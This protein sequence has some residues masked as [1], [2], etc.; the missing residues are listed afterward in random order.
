MKSKSLVTVPHNRYLVA[1]MAVILYCT[2]GISAPVM[3]Q[4]VSTSTASVVSTS[5]A[6][7]GSTS[8]GRDAGSLE[9]VV[10]TAEK[11]SERLQDVPVPVTAL[12]AVTLADRNQFRIQDYFTQ[13]PGLALTPNENNGTATIAI[14]GITSGDNTNPTVGI[15]VD[16]IPFGSSTSIGAG[17]FAPDFDPSD[18]ARV[19]VLRGPQ[20]TLYGASSIGGLLKYVTVDPSFAGVSGRVEAGLASVDGGGNLGYNVSAGV[21]IPLTDSL[22][23]RISG[24]TRDN[25]GYIHNVQSGETDVNKTTVTG[26]HLSALWRPTDDFSLKL[27]ALYQDNKIF[28]SSFVTVE[29]GLGDWQQRFLPGTG[30]VDRTFEVFSANMS[31]ILGP[32]DVTSVTGYSVSRLHDFLDYTE[33]FGFITQGVFNTNPP[34]T[35]AGDDTTTYKFNQEIRLA[36]KIGSKVDLLL[37]GYYTH[38]RSPYLLQIIGADAAGQSIGGEAHSAFTS[39]YAEWSGFANLTY[40]FTD[41]FDVQV[42]GRGTS[43][44]ETFNETDSGPYVPLFENA[45]S[46]NSYGGSEQDHAFTYLV[47]PRYVVSQDLMIYARLASGYRPGGI[48][49]GVSPGQPV[50]P[51]FKHDTTENYELG[52]KGNAFDHIFSFDASVYHID[53]RDIQLALLNQADGQVYFSNGSRAKS[54]GVEVSFEYIP[55]RQ[56]HLSGWVDVNDAELTQPLPGNSPVNGPVGSRLP[57]SSR[58]SAN[59]AMDYEVPL[60]TITGVVGGGVSYVGD[61]TGA[62][63]GTGQPQP[64]RQNL[65]GF[66]IASIHAGAKWDRWDIHADVN[67]LLNR[68]GVL[69]GGVGTQTPDAFQFIQPRTIG[70][71]AAMTF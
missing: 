37:G 16:D 69:G 40:H 45:T 13:V 36:T 63:V 49:A 58:F 54:E 32:F 39:S 19:E 1:L 42:G 26:G 35:L 14:R 7:D 6:S 3:A 53:W 56:L 24:F 33:V 60:G 38:E 31:G 20:G 70:L 51:N 8:G 44:S 47:T 59:T 48:N 29:P 65:P 2:V 9:E 18:L 43:I 25:P 4:L 11:H 61:R 46:P 5:T 67:N 17:Y 10:V 50:E 71:S 55:V 68:Y 27:S 62:F 23:V 30:H 41:H 34:Y 22:A 28:G 66:A 15:T 21:N 57:Y 64:S 52:V 12:S